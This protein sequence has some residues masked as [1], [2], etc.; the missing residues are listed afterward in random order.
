MNED[1]AAVEE[2]GNMAKNRLW[3][4]NLNKKE[5]NSDESEQTVSPTQ[6]AGLNV[7]PC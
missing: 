4:T 1:S 3:A 2:M 7:R 6:L 5:I